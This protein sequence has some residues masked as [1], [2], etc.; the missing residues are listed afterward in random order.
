MHG[1]GVLESKEY[2]Y[3]GEF[4]SN[5]FHGDGELSLKNK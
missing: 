3:S 1:R 2:I 5:K 4:N